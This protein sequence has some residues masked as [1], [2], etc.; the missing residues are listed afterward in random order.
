MPNGTYDF[1]PEGVLVE[2]IKKEKKWFRK[3]LGI[4]ALHTLKQAQFDDVRGTKWKISDTA[5][6]LGMSVG[7]ISES[8]QLALYNKVDGR[9]DKMTR[10]TALKVVREHSMRL[11]K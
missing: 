8:I 1:M 10:D 6:L 11:V 2:E 5:S 7:Y 4:L 3:C 9:L